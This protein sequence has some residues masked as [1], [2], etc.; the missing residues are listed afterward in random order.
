MNIPSVTKIYTALEEKH[1][2]D[3]AEQVIIPG[4]VYS[5]CQPGS[6]PKDRNLRRY[7]TQ[8]IYYREL[9]IQGMETEKPNRGQ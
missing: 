4:A 9:V 5:L 2:C 8:G 1:M 6:I 3:G 7:F